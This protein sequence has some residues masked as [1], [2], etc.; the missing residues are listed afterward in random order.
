LLVR[1]PRQGRFGLHAECLHGLQQGRS[2]TGIEEYLLSYVEDWLTQEAARGIFNIL[3]YPRV[4]LV[5]LIFPIATPSPA[6]A[7]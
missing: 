1:K 4:P 5:P 6:N 3:S 2:P 7:L